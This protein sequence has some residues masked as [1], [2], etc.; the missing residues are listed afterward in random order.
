M[1]LISQI[2]IYSDLP[3]SYHVV[4]SLLTGYKRPNDK[5]HELLKK[6]ILAPVKKGLYI[7]GP[8][9]KKTTSEP[10][11]LANHIWGPSYVSLDSALSYYGF[12]P[13][14][15]YGFTSVTVKETKSYKTPS[16]IFSYRH[17]SPPYY[18]FGIRQMEI[19][20]NKYALIASPEKAVCDK[21]IMTSGVLLRSRKEVLN[22]LTEDL[23][24]DID[25]L[26]TLNTKMIEEWISKAPK[27]SSI[28]M[29]VK[30]LKML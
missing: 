19:L 29:L 21:I 1:D 26:R 10:F 7:A 15:V 25:M 30:S 8:Q 4:R 28:E 12:I 23:R 18:A 3:M 22:Y 2:S 11:L 24:M 20:N 17:Q 6:G 14:R 9:I 13:E 27:K 5:I 16:G